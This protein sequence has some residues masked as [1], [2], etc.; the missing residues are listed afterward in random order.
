VAILDAAV[1]LF[2][3][4]PDA[5]L[6][7]AAG[8]AGVTRQTVYAHFATREELVLA[9]VE[10]GGAESDATLAAAAL[11]EGAAADALGRLLELGFGTLAAHPVLLLAPD[12]GRH[13]SIAGRLTALVRRGQAAGEFDAGLDPAWGAAAV[14][15]LGHAAG[16]EI[17]AGRL[18]AGDAHAAV[19]LAALRV[20]GHQPR[21]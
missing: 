13:G 5:G 18:P 19:R 14:I 3:Q 15:A 20:L 4:Q 7:A 6:A 1:R 8:E 17:T 12:A 11:E 2:S 16:A 21:G 9:V 10:R